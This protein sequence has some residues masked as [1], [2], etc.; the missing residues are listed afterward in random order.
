MNLKLGITFMGLANEQFSPFVHG[1]FH[2]NHHLFFVEVFLL[3]SQV[4]TDFY[5]VESV[6]DGLTLDFA[7]AD[8]VFEALETSRIYYLNL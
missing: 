4:I 2:I 6:R 7:Q 5:V 1:L 8:V 3:V